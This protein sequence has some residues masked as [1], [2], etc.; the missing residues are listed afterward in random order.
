MV[1]REAKPCAEGRNLFWLRANVHVSITC[2]NL[3]ELS[4]IHDLTVD[5]VAA[6][7][8]EKRCVVFIVGNVLAMIY[9]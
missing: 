6:P 5:Y 4:N 1:P 8:W 3:N 7:L 2:L 9:T